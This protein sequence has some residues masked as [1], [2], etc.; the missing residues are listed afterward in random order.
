MIRTAIRWATVAALTNGGN[1]PY[2]TLAGINVYDSRVDPLD[3]LAIGERKPIIIVRTEED[4]WQHEAHGAPSELTL[5]RHLNLGLDISIMTAARAQ[6]GSVIA[7]WPA[8]D[9]VVEAWLDALELECDAALRGF[10]PWAV[11]YT[12]QRPGWIRLSWTSS[13]NY[14]DDDRTSARLAARSI[15]IRM[16]VPGECLLKPLRDTDT[17]PAGKLPDAL[18]AVF[19][20]ISRDGAGDVKTAA[21]QARASLE[22][23]ALPVPPVYPALLKVAFSIPETEREPTSLHPARIEGDLLGAITLAFVAAQE[24]EIV[25]VDVTQWLTAE[26]QYQYRWYRNGFEIGGARSASYL[27]SVADIGKELAMTVT[28][29]NIIGSVS[30]TLVIGGVLENDEE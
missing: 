23:R 27:I 3:D 22:S 9:A 28:A 24:D 20:K 17:V 12:T 26:S 21:A 16:K 30:R 6:D 10:S 14:A 13:P 2:P 5:A 1:Q 19:D 15:V 25:T 8:T 4:E 29:T 7:G 18:I 11:W